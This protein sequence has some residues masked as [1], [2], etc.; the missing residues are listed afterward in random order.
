[1]GSLPAARDWLL[2]AA[3]DPAAAA[4]LLLFHHA[5]GGASAYREWPGLLPSD[6]AVQRV[7]LPGR[8]ERR[9]E[10][11]YDR[12]D[13]LVAALTAL[14]AAEP[15]GRP[16]AFFG[17]SMGALLAYRTA[18][19]LE[20]AGR[21][22]PAL[23]AVS[24]WAPAGAPD[25]PPAAAMTDAEVAGWMRALGA[26]PR[27][28]DADPDALAAAVRTMRADLAV[29]ESHRDD[30]ARLGC[31]IVVYGGRDD[32]LVPAG[33]LREWAARTGR[34]LGTRIFPGGH[35]F[36]HDHGQAVTADLVSLL[37]RHAAR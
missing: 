36:L 23:L 2:P 24:G 5:G 20:R 33:A 11:P 32:P 18:V 8:Q 29:C 7:Q 1:M 25:R 30:G 9:R 21:P 13:P 34:P 37:R 22:G 17:H 10:A 19:A 26:L 27:E 12:L 31:P 16:Y 4:R 14:L 15:D 3:A 35:F 28:V 6:L